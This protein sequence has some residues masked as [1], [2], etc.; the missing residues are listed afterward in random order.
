MSNIVDLSTFK[1]VIFRNSHLK[2]KYFCWLLISNIF[3]LTNIPYP[4]NFKIAILRFFGAKVGLRCIIKPWV[5]IKFPWELELGNNVWI[6]EEAW[7]DNISKITLGNNVCIS[8]GALLITGNHRYDLSD[9]PL[10]SNPITVEDGVWICSKAIVT[11]GV[12]LGNHA[13]LGIGTKTSKDLVS[14][15]VYQSDGIIKNRKIIK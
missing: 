10:E 8:Q 14:Y 11:G 13:V 9:F 12:I 3:F 6:G 1:H 5:K 2:F 7:I 15:K 4:N